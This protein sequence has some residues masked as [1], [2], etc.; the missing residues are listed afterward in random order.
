VASDL[1]GGYDIARHGHGIWLAFLKVLMKIIDRYLIKSFLVPFGVC[2][3]VFSILVVLGRFFDKM[4]IFNRFHAHPKEILVFLFLGLPFWLNMVLP[5]ATMLALLFSLG[6]LHQRGEFTAFRSAGIPSWRLYLPFVSIGGLLA[7]LSLVGSLTVLPKLN[8]ESRKVYRVKIKKRD[9]LE[10]R[11]DNIVVA[12][13]DR[14]RFTIGWLD[15]ENQQLRD[16]VVDRFGEDLKW[17]ETYSAKLASYDHGRWL[18]QDGVYRRKDPKA[19]EGF[20][21]DSFSRRWFAIPETPSDFALED[22]EPDDMTG[23]ELL[24]R[25]ERLK[26][27]GAPIHRENVAWHMRLALPYAN[28]LVIALAIP[29]ALRSGVQGRVQNFSYALSLAFFYWGITSVCQSFGE[30]GQ[31]PAWMAA[32]M[33]NFL[34]SGLATWRLAQ[35]T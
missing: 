25:A 24:D 13:R 30:Q 4:D 8:F 11:K 14:R 9:V 1:V 16:V 20:R 19:P 27:L 23:R 28:V 29:Y 18:F 17:V 34:F 22:K 5:V 35:V 6:Q 32:W 3:C 21:E 12:G 15:V 31:M 7:L 26:R 33:S 10:Y 2:V